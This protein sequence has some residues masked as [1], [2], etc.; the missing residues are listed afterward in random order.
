M[1]HEGNETRDFRLAMG[2][3]GFC[4]YYKICVSMICR[5]DWKERMCADK[6][7]FEKF[8]AKCKSVYTPFEFVTIDEKL[9][10]FRAR[11]SSKQYIPNKPI[12]CGIKIALFNSK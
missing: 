8:V 4:F 2:K 12:K 3:P 7:F 11:C 10:A 1:E 5:S 9:E 6:R